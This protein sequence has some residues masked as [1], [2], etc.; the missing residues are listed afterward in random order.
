MKKT[1]IGVVTATASTYRPTMAGVPILA[2]IANRPHW[3][4]A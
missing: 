3:Q 2:R 1:V 4:S